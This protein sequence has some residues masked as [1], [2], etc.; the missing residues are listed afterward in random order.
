MRKQK[1][2][3]SIFF[4]LMISGAVARPVVMLTG[5]WH[6]TNEMLY[7]F[8]PDP[9]L[10][11]EGWIGE[12][13]E[14]RGYDVYA[15]FPAFDITTREFEVDYQATW[16]DFWA[17]VDQFTPEIIISF[18]AG[19][20]P[21]EIETQAKNLDNW[22]ADDEYP[23]YPTPNPPDSTLAA[24]ASRYSTLPNFAIEAA[25]N[26]QTNINAWVDIYGDPGNYLCN[27]IAYL[28]MWYQNMNAEP[29]A[30]NYCRAAGFVHVN[31][32]LE[33]AAVTEAAEI[34][35]RTTLQFYENMAQLNGTII[36][37]GNLENAEI[38]LTDSLGAEYEAQTDAEG[39]FNFAEL[40]YDLYQ[41]EAR[42]GRYFYYQGEFDFSADN[43]FLEIEM[44]EF[45]AA[46]PLT[47]SAGAV[48]LINSAA[49]PVIFV[50]A[51]YPPEM[52]TA[53]ADCHLNRLYFSA[54][55]NS[56]DCNL[57][58]KLYRGD[59]LAGNMDIVMAAT[60][61][62][63]QQGHWVEVW[64]DDF[65]LLTE[66]DLAEGLTLA[67]GIVNANNNIGYTDGLSANPNG[68]LLKLGTTWYSAATE[69]G[70]EGNWDLALGFNGEPLVTAENQLPTTD[71]QLS[72]YPNPFNPTT[73]ISFTTIKD[74]QKT[75]VIIYN[76]KGQTVK[77][78]IEQELAAGPHSIIWNG[79]DAA[80]KTVSSGVYF[81]QV[82][83]QLSSEMNKMLLLK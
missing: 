34:T 73:T 28:G 83:T 67:Y 77:K 40:P 43:D 53:Y 68:N 65:Y 12:N 42:L 50:G 19:N 22:V 78:L 56:T 51:H 70:I 55:E 11:P 6:P 31:A 20:G 10:N 62:A 75:E 63:F 37:A 5:Y 46:A 80:G 3:L 45:A 82:K 16:N 59:P 24:N 54:P 39:N 35:L 44:Q 17:R 60:L 79:D 7:R 4:L 49:A 1:I 72:N 66:D 47:Y 23:Y 76:L 74:R 36:A 71:L 33:L 21:W 2:Y 15:F 26:E 18:G 8:S 27:Y 57:Q 30:E 29:E 52:L 81:Y 32:A 61:P 38:Y 13:W 25:V 14:N 41:V 64:L 9:E 48:D 69:L 58:L